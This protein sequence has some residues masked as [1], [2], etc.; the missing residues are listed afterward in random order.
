MKNVIE[1]SIGQGVGQGGPL[2]PTP[3]HLDEWRTPASG[4]HGDQ[5]VKRCYTV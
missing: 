4:G 5:S 1:L 2:D 3:V